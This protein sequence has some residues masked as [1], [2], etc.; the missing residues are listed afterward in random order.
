MVWE[1]MQIHAANEKYGVENQWFGGLFSGFLRGHIFNVQ[2][3][4]KNTS[5]R[6]ILKIDIENMAQ[7]IIIFS[8]VGKNSLYA[9]FV[10][11]EQH[12]LRVTLSR[13]VAGL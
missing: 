12:I 7:R 1:G 3:P 8:I 13:P 6:L 4:R 5:G 11:K 10:F 2:S 9:V